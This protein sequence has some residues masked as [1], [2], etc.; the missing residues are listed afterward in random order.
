MLSIHD[1]ASLSRRGIQI[2]TLPPIGVAP[3]R[4]APEPGHRARCSVDFVDQSSGA[5]Q[6]RKNAIE[7]PIRTA[8][9]FVSL[10]IGVNEIEPSAWSTMLPSLR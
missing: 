7:I 3:P 1:S 9:R 8:I 6:S 4:P 10:S 2:R 5:G